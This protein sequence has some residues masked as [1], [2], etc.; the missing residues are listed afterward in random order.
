MKG[1][2]NWLSLIGAGMCIAALLVSYG[3]SWAW[4]MIG[5]CVLWLPS[6][7][8]RIQAARR[9]HA[10]FMREVDHAD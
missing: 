9:A 8:L 1:W 5:G 4:V 7:V 2:L 3:V 6:N 10:E